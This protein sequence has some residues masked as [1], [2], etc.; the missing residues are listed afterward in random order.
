MSINLVPFSSVSINLFIHLLYSL[1]PLSTTETRSSP[2]NF[3]NDFPMGG[4]GAPAATDGAPDSVLAPH[5][6]KKSSK[7]KS[8]NHL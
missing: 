1:S 7:N 4:S 3:P 2:V 6:T 5:V 8:N